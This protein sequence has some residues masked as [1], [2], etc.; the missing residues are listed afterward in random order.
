MTG[1]SFAAIVAAGGTGSRFSKSSKAELPKQFMSLR[2][3]P[4]YFHSLLSFLQNSRISRVILVTPSHMVQLAKT[5][6]ADLGKKVSQDKEIEVIAGGASRQA[7][8]FCGL[9]Y[10]QE[11]G[12]IPDYVLVHDAAR[13][14]LDNE[15]LERI[16]DKVIECGACT[17][18]GA[19]SDT[20]K[21]VAGGKIIETLPRNEL[22]AVQT[23]Q[24]SAFAPLLAAHEEALLLKY[25]S[26][27]DSS[28]LEWAGHE[29]H[30][31]EGSPYNI[32]VT[33]PLDLM[34]AEQLADYLL[35]D[36]L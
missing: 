26:T 6:S 27:D 28:L 9:K 11:C 36:L 12:E 31:V 35:K 2:G 21:K 4:L 22:V 3:Q 19:V 16:M 5:E 13:P 33:Q 24:A 7:S 1:A 8:V 18:G 14:F 32:K 10:L 30:V 20:I 17:V 23:P 15:T 34:L 25:S 29:V